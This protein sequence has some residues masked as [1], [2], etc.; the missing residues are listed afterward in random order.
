[1]EKLMSDN[2]IR[3]HAEYEGKRRQANML[4]VGYFWRRMQRF[5]DYVGQLQT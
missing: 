2:K 1:M 3:Y 5:V 4:D